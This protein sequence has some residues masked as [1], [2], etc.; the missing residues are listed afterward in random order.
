MGDRRV[1]LVPAAAQQDMVPFS[2][3]TSGCARTP[4][5]R[6]G[7]LSV[8]G[9]N[10]NTGVHTGVES[11]LLTLRTLTLRGQIKWTFSYFCDHFRC[12]DIWSH[13]RMLMMEST[14]FSHFFCVLTHRVPITEKWPFFV[15]NGWSRCYNRVTPIMLQIPLKITLVHTQTKQIK[16]IISTVYVFWVAAS[17]LPIERA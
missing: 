15:G 11:F 9:H 10:Q 7:L 17:V 5:S 6:W 13:L 2:E 4:G 12:G 1:T 8:T 16:G 14:F 3:I